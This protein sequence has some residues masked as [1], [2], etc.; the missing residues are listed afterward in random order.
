MLVWE[1]PAVRVCFTGG[2]C[3]GATARGLVALALTLRS[4]VVEVVGRSVSVRR[5][6]SWASVLARFG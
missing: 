4:L 3:A 5:R 6:A 1:H 2:L